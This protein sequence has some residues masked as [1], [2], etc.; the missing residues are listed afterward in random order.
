MKALQHAYVG[1]KLKKRDFRS[2]WTTQINAAARQYE[3]PYSRLIYGLK[4]ANI[5][6]N[7]R[8][9]AALAQTE[10]DS[11]EAAVRVAQQKLKDKWGNMYTATQTLAL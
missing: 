2:L 1:R 7:R 4:L 11:F 8:S 10:P 5:S 3:L 9:L 6:L